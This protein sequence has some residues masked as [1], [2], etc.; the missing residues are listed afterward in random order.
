MF[1]VDHGDAT[2][3][4]QQ[5]GVF[6]ARIRIKNPSRGLWPAFW[7]EGADHGTVGWP[8]DGEVDTFEA[9][10]QQPTTIQQHIEGGHTLTTMGS[11]WSLPPGESIA[12]WH[13][14]SVTWSPSMIQWS[15][16]GHTTLTLTSSQVGPAWAASFMHPMALRLDLTVGGNRP[17][18]ADATSTFPA[19]MVV[20]WVRVSAQPG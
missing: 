13:T 5:F 18:A 14:Y 20:D 1:D 9:V 12:G 15:V 16:D 6:A 7:M 2:S 10:G 17:G 8:L 19:E 4:S 11:G 3:W